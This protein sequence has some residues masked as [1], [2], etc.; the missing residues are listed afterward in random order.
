MNKLY[1]LLIPI[2]TFVAVFAAIRLSNN[3]KKSCSS[4]SRTDFIFTESIQQR[5]TFQKQL[6][7][8]REQGEYCDKINDTTYLS[9]YAVVEDGKRVIKKRTLLIKEME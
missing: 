1:F 6:D 8:L 4:E 9:S 5:I 2:L 3:S 7:E